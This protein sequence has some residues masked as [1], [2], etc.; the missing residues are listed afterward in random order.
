L[1][2]NYSYNAIAVTHLIPA[3]EGSKYICNVS[4]D[5]IT[6]DGHKLKGLTTSTTVFSK[7]TPFDIM[8]GGYTNLSVKETIK[9]E[10]YLIHTDQNGN[11]KGTIAYIDDLSIRFGYTY[12]VAFNNVAITNNIAS[13]DKIRAYVVPTESDVNQSP[14][15]LKGKP[16][17]ISEINLTTTSLQSPEE[18]E[19]RVYGNSSGVVIKGESFVN[20]KAYI[21][22][23]SGMVVDQF[24][25]TSAHQ[26]RALAKGTYIVKIG[27]YTRKITL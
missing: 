4:M 23:L 24:I 18:K 27:T 14:V 7:N 21:Y 3:I 16:H 1:T 25:V 20:Q 22:D 10:I 19:T 5:T 11:D 12:Y 9:G 6:M 8:I 15:W 17:V 13:G 26:T 2:D